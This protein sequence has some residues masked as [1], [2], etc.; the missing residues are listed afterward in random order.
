[1]RILRT[2]LYPFFFA[3]LVVSLLIGFGGDSGLSGATETQPR[4]PVT[5]LFKDVKE[6]P[7]HAMPTAA[8]AATASAATPGYKIISMAEAVTIAERTVHG[9][10]IKAERLERPVIAYKVEIVQLDG[11]RIAVDLAA[12]GKFLG[13]GPP[14]PPT[15][16]KKKGGN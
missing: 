8:V 11:S 14:P 1:M 3:G 10:T 6:T 15:M 12:D 16:G 13:K 4:S 9:Y 2:I 5:A 7:P